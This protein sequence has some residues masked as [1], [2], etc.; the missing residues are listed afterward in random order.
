MWCCCCAKPF[1]VLLLPHVKYKMLYCIPSTSTCSVLP[2]LSSFTLCSAPPG[3]LCR[4]SHHSSSLSLLPVT[5]CWICP[6]PPAGACLKHHLLH[7]IVPQPPLQPAPFSHAREPGAGYLSF[8]C[9]F[10][11]ICLVSD[12]FLLL[13]HKFH[14]DKVCVPLV[15][16]CI[17][18]PSSYHSAVSVHS[19]SVEWMDTQQQHVKKK[20]WSTSFKPVGLSIKEYDRGK[21]RHQ[22]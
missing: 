1:R 9:S 20:K 4:V 16:L 22:P 5:V 12:L 19:V 7:G 2:S 3:F 6:P 14:K 15:H 11:F 18:T 17:P 8:S 10:A 21:R 13:V